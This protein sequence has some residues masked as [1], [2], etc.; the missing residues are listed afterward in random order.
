MATAFACNALSRFLW[1]SV[2]DRQ[3]VCRDLQ[4]IHTIPSNGCRGDQQHPLKVTHHY[5]RVNCAIRAG[6]QG[7]REKKGLG[8]RSPATGYAPA[9]GPWVRGAGDGCRILPSNAKLTDTKTDTEK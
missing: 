1:G 4:H 5:Q 8:F 9:V 6:A 7:W 3:V 2:S